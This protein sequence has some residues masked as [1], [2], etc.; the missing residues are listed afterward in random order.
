VVDM[1]DI[2]FVE[3][4]MKKV[5]DSD[6]KMQ[7]TP[8][9]YEQFIQVVNLNSTVTKLWIHVIDNLFLEQEEKIIDLTNQIETLKEEIEELE[10][11]LE[12]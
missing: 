6:F 8:E 3:G 7:L 1:V 2:D 5:L 9:V 12:E 10:Q 4:K 11:E